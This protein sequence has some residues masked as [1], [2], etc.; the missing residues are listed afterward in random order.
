[1]RKMTAIL[2]DEIDSRI[3]V[4]DARYRR[5]LMLTRGPCAAKADA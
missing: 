2:D 5:R 4:Q 3:P 1:M